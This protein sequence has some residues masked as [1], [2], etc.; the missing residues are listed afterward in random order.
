MAEKLKKYKEKQKVK[1]EQVEKLL[2]EYGV[3]KKYIL[4]GDP[5]MRNFFLLL[6][7]G[8]LG[9]GIYV[10]VKNPTDFDDSSD[11][12][13]VAIV[14]LSAILAFGYY[15]LY[16]YRQAEN[17]RVFDLFSEEIEKTNE[18]MKFRKPEEKTE[19]NENRERLLSAK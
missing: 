6:A 1:E 18:I 16:N 9:C 11:I 15:Y 7:F 17:K 8:I 10:I 3:F 19:K 5:N 2:Q 13:V 4:G 14:A 12:C